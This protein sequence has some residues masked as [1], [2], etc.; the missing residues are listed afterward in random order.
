MIVYTDITSN[1][2][3]PPGLVLIYDL[4]QL[5]PSILK[6]DKLGFFIDFLPFFTPTPAFLSPTSSGTA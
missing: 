3:D 1:D 4:M 6:T 2:T 5:F